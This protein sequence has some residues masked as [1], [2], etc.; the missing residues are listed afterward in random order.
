[1]QKY[2]GWLVVHPDLNDHGLA[3]F[4]QQWSELVGRHGGRV[5][6]ISVYGKRKL[7]YRIKKLW[8]G[9]AMEVRMEM[10]PKQ[11]ESFQRAA[12][13]LESLL[14]LMIVRDDGIPPADF[15]TQTEA[16]MDT[17]EEGA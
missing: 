14:R 11:V 3:Q 16:Q 5:L 4:Q 13:L 15:L 17:T 7:S 10:D 9:Y 8:E 6:G 2:L 12:L 1:M